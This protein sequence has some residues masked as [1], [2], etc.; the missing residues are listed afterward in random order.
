[1]TGGP[2]IDGPCWERVTPP[3]PIVLLLSFTSVCW[4]KVTPLPP[5][6]L[7]FDEKV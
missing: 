1:M 6:E 7:G 4:P 2:S 5:A 3:Q